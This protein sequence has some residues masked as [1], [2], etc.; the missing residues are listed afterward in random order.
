MAQKG[1][2]NKGKDKEPANVI[3]PFLEE[4]VTFIRT[5]LDSERVPPPVMDKRKGPSKELTKGTENPTNESEFS[6]ENVPREYER[7]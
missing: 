3:P 7:N 4:Q 6:G 1:A 5:L 2:A